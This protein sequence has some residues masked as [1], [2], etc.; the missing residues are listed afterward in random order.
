MATI[1]RQH[2]YMNVERK[3]ARGGSRNLPGGTISS[4]FLST[5]LSPFPL[6]VGSPLYQLGGSGGTL[7]ESHQT[8]TCSATAPPVCRSAPG[9]L[10][11]TSAASVRRLSH[12]CLLRL[13]CQRGWP[14]TLT[15]RIKASATVIVYRGHR[16]TLLPARDSLFI[17]CI[18]IIRNNSL[19]G[20]RAR[21]E[22]NPGHWARH[23]LL[24]MSAEWE[25][26]KLNAVTIVKVTSTWSIL[27]PTSAQ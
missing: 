1:A 6:Q 26:M 19:V 15:L 4:T 3:K 22:S 5:L 13:S 14:D 21:A 7:G 25:F 8:G 10:T 20:G 2:D 16:R 27:Q 12:V 17:M 24:H 9:H 11:D 23:A 18:G